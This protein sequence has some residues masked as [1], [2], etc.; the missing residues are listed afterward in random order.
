MHQAHIR[1][2]IQRALNNFTDGELHENA[3]HLLKVLGYQSQRILNRDTN[4]TEAFR[5][6][7]DP[8]NRINPEKAHLH[9][10]Q[11]AD[12]LFQLTADEIRQ[13]TQETFTF[14]EDPGV[15]EHIYQ[16]SRQD[17]TL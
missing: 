1:I 9:E 5:E 7:F 15:D 11:I 8:D 17:P 12:F 4:T 16:S 14:N 10:W 3:T 2:D 6:D 13:H